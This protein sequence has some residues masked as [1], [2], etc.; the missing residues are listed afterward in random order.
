M[1]LEVKL[2]RCESFEPFAKCY[3]LENARVEQ[4]H[5]FSRSWH[6]CW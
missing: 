1:Q 4:G 2:W 3:E 5:R 6:S